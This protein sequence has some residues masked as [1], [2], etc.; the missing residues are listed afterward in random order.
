M[1]KIKAE[2]VGRPQRNKIKDPKTAS[3]MTSAIWDGNSPQNAYNP[4]RAAD[5][6]QV[7]AAVLDD[8]KFNKV[9]EECRYFYRKDPIANTTIDKLVELGVTELIIDKGSLSDN[10]YR[11]L[12]GIKPKVL[13]F[14]RDGALEFLV[15]GMVVPSITFEWKRKADLESIGVKKY[16]KAWLPKDMWYRNP[17]HLELEESFI[18]REPTYFLK[19]PDSYLRRLKNLLSTGRQEDTK[20]VTDLMTSFPGFVEQLKAGEKKVI[21]KDKHSLFIRRKP[22]VDTPYPTPYLYAAIESLQHKR[23]IRAMDFALASRVIEAIQIFRLGDKDFP[24]TKETEYQLEDLKAQIESRYALSPASIERVFQLFGNHTLQIEWVI[25][26]V[27]ALLDDAK[28]AEVNNDI[29]YALGFPRILIVGESERS[30]SSDHDF[31]TLSPVATMESFRGKLLRIAKYIF[32]EV[33]RRNDLGDYGGVR[34]EQINLVKFEQFSQALL[35]L[36]EK[37]NLSRESIADYYGYNWDEEVHKRKDEK[38][39][40]EELGLDEYNPQ[41]FDKPMDQNVP[42]TPQNKPKQDKKE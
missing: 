24:L 4:W 30:G 34:F 17:K 29:I 37:G 32:D 5:T 9:V 16:T 8:K 15:S 35:E 18:S 25:P 28:Y 6:K 11:I 1:A 26:P 40:L 42:N 19:I 27:E 41:P 2:A 10:Q 38:D 3:H 21:L 39:L 36:Y 33:V 22:M 31:A 13:D 20:L 7:K 12:E 23:N 14:M